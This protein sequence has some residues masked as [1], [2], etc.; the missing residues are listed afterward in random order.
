MRRSWN[1]V[2]PS[3][4]S[5][6]A[7]LAHFAVRAS[8]LQASLAFYAE[9][10]DLHIGPRPPFGFPGAWLYLAAD[11]AREDQGCVHLI[12][13]GPNGALSDYLGDRRADGRS[14]AGALDLISA[15]RN[16]Q[17][18]TA[19]AGIEFGGEIALSDMAVI[20][21]F[22]GYE[23]KR[24]VWGKTLDITAALEGAPAGVAPFTVSNSPD[25]NLHQASGGVDLIGGAGWS[26]R[27]LYTGTFG[28]TTR[29]DL[30]SVK[31]TMP[32]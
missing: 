32:F 1:A 28:N 27:A 17:T 22:A 31:V 5:M 20:R 2:R 21:P 18:G 30:Y 29:Q 24:T 14:G 15:G 8:D 11:P 6:I 25:V 4:A 23:F 12:G 26:M 7:Q 3:G 16:H 19:G 10:L 13:S 9:V